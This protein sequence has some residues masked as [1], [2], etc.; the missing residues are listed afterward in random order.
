MTHDPDRPRCSARLHRLL[1]VPLVLTLAVLPL[2]AGHGWD[3]SPPRHRN[4]HPAHVRSI[5][6]RAR[7]AHP[8]VVVVPSRLAR[9]DLV[10]YRR[11]QRGDDWYE[12]HRHVHAVF[13]FP[14]RTEHGVMWLRTSY[15]AGARFRSGVVTYDGPRLRVQARF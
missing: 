8:V 6:V 14:V 7:A 3:K 9:Y 2:Q 15:C 11:F 5:G 10:R 4:P 13:V 1:F 12:P